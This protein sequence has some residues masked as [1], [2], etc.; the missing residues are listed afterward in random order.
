MD[1]VVEGEFKW[2]CE[3]YSESRFEAGA[4]ADS[5]MQAGRRSAQAGGQGG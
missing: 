4:V 3:N 1:T 5:R 2:D